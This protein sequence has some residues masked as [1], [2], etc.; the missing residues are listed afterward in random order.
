M[1]EGF[2]LGELLSSGVGPHTDPSFQKVHFSQN[3]GFL[4]L[5]PVLAG[6]LFSL[7]FGRNLDAH[8]PTR[9]NVHHELD[10]R[11]RGGLPSTDARHQCLEGRLCY[12]DSA[13][14][15]IVACVVA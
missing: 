2:G 11:P 15:T 13:T 8:A 7:V 4:S 6:N 12:A 5:S 10:H 9:T 14:L 3:W 1:I